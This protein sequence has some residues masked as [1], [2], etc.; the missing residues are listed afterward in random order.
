MYIPQKRQHTTVHE[1]ISILLYIC[2]FTILTCGSC[3]HA[4]VLLDS[5]SAAE[6]DVRSVCSRM[7]TY[8]DVS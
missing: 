7:L 2:I 4:G 6:A 1:Y 8:A 3:L 5:R